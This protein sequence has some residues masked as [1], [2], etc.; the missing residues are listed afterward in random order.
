[1]L[2][3]LAATLWP[4]GALADE[5]RGWSSVQLRLVEVIHP[6]HGVEGRF[7]FCW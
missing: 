1:M 2:V 3:V 7:L 6:N 5:V 4:K